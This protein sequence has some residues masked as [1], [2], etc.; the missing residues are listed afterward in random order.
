MNAYTGNMFGARKVAIR[1]VRTDIGSNVLRQAGGRVLRV[2]VHCAFCESMAALQ[3]NAG[4]KPTE[5]RKPNILGEGEEYN[6]QYPQPPTTKCRGGTNG[7]HRA[8]LYH[9]RMRGRWLT[10]PLLHTGPPWLWQAGRTW[11]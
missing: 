8:N 1:K 11:S 6:Q 10:G 7:R 4:T 3:I 5:V 2:R 9:L